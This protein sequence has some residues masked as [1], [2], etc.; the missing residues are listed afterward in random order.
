MLNGDSEA[1]LAN[2]QASAAW[3]RAT[4]ARVVPSS[5]CVSQLIECE[6][7]PPTEAFVVI[8]IGA[9]TFMGSEGGV[10]RSPS[11]AS[12]R[13]VDSMYC[14]NVVQRDQGGRPKGGRY[15]ESTTSVEYV[16]W[17]TPGFQTCVRMRKC[18]CLTRMGA[19]I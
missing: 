10:W 8:A 9:L 5:H 7:V 3:M 4:Q 11:P 17:S 19:V 18:G 13:T 16:Q 6:R 1:L 2:N 15:C 12:M 14:N